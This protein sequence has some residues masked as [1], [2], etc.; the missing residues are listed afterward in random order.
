FS[1]DVIDR[2]GGSTAA[3]ANLDLQAINDAP[4]VSAD[5]VLSNGAEDSKIQLTSAMLL[6]NA[7][8]VDINDLGKLSVDNL[9]ADHGSITSNPDGSFTFT[10]EKNYNGA[11]HLSYDVKD[12]HGGVTHTGAST[13]LSEVNDAGVITGDKS[14]TVS[15][16][17][18]VQGDAQHTIYTVGVLDVTDPDAGENHFHENHNVHALHDPFGGSF[19]IGKAGDWSYSVP[20]SNVQHLAKDQVETVQ[21]EVLTQGGD[22]QIVTVSIHGT[23][24]APT[25]SVTQTTPTTGTLLETD[26]D[27]KDTHSFSVVNSSGQFG[28]L[29]V[30]PSSGAYVYTPN[31]SISGMSY[32]S[33]TRTYHGTEVFEV[34]VADNHGGESSRFI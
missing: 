14:G 32:N 22:K 2:H 15:E 30:D 17:N 31:S 24:D 6:A 3:N 1:Y 12:A 29:S 20:N 33:A 5:V 25:L 23:N 19:T 34:K 7:T 8:D 18:H 11:V 26:V 9:H 10:P 21:Y 13:T 4:V 28:D 16:D 27:V